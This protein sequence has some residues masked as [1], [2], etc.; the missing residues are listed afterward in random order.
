MCGRESRSEDSRLLN[1]KHCAIEIDG[2]DPIDRLLGTR[3][4]LFGRDNI[5]QPMLILARE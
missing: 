3:L 4:C 2:L 5:N 1:H